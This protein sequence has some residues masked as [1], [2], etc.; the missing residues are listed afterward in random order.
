PRLMA[1]KSEFARAM[2]R[3]MLGRRLFVK[4]RGYIGAGPLSARVGDAVCVLAGGHVPLVLREEHGGNADGCV[5]LIGNCYVH[6]VMLG[7]AVE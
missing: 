1:D 4:K 2:A 6:G 7:E 5:T 3:I